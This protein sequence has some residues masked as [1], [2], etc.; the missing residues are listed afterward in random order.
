[1]AAHSPESIGEMMMAASLKFCHPIRFSEH[2]Y[3]MHH[4]IEWLNQQKRAGRPSFV[5]DNLMAKG[6]FT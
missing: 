6:T 4:K 3:R 5:N 1:M 2:P